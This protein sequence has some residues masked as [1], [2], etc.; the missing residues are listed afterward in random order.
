L[1]F[2]EEMQTGVLILS[3]IQAQDAQSRAVIPRGVLKHGVPPQ[4]D[5]LEVDLHEIAPAAPSRTVATGVGAG[6]VSFAAG[7]NHS[8]AARGGVRQFDAVAGRA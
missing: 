8:G 5:D 7:E 4:L 2:T 6:A 1:H 3:R